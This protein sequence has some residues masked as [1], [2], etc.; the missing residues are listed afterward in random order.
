[1]TLGEI[2]S[3]HAGSGVF[4]IVIDRK[5][6]AEYYK[7]WGRCVKE[8][9][10]VIWTDRDRNVGISGIKG[11]RVFKKGGKEINSGNCTCELRNLHF[12]LQTDYHLDQ[13]R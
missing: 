4:V 7:Q 3:T 9:C 11:K 6:K 13:C 10:A 12:Q 8:T 5:S 1:M 2:K